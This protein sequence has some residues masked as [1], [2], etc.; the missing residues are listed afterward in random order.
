MGKKAPQ[1]EHKIFS[2]PSEPQVDDRS[3]FLTVMTQ[4][5]FGFKSQLR[6]KREE[7]LIFFVLC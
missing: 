3:L 6:E 2:V 1:T 7:L 5:V 4:G